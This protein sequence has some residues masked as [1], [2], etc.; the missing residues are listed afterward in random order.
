MLNSNRVLDALKKV[1]DPEIG[2]NLVD[3]NFI[4]EVD[5][6]DKRILI[7]M[8][9]TSPF[10]PLASYLV[11]EVKRKAQEVAEGRDV[12][13]VVLDEPWVPPERFR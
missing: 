3:L 13:V 6:N 2:L 10:C 5:I 1:I 4:K 11:N 12:E 9:L 7:K 8:V